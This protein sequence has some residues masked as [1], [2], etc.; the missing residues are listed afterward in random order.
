MRVFECYCSR[1][2]FH[3]LS[4]SIRPNSLI[5][6]PLSFPS[7]AHFSLSSSVLSLALSVSS[8]SVPPSRGCSIFKRACSAQVIL[9]AARE[10][11]NK[12]L[13]VEKGSAVHWVHSGDASLRAGRRKDGGDG[14]GRRGRLWK[15]E[16]TARVSSL[17]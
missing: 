16:R 6:L 9:A 15:Q 8:L 17:H 13:M 12:S 1:L 4:L 14:K 3:V 2:F 5:R 11:S 7:F 10:G